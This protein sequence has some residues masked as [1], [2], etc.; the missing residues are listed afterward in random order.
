MYA[1]EFTELEPDPTS[2]EG[3]KRMKIIMGSTDSR[4]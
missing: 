4:F 1:R 2:W 3:G